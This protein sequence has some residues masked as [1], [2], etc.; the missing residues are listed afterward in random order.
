MKLYYAAY[1]SLANKYSY[2][3]ASAANK[4]RNIGGVLKTPL[5]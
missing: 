1:A 2:A 4:N 5:N 3:S